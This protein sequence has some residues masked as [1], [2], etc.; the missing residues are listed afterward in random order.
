MALADDNT[1]IGKET[2]GQRALNWCSTVLGIYGNVTQGD[3]CSNGCFA[4]GTM[5]VNS[6]AFTPINNLPYKAVLDDTHLFDRSSQT[7]WFQASYPLTSAAMCSD[8]GTTIDLL[9]LF[10][11]FRFRFMFSG[12]DSSICG[13]P[14]DQ[15][16]EL[17]G[18][19]VRKRAGLKGTS[20]RL[21]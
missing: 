4:V 9:L 6:G 2:Q 14:T 16:F 15:I 12:S 5:D 11:F 17:D 13:Y 1:I 10:D 18:L 7:L 8:T 21:F 20:K 19:P 3:W